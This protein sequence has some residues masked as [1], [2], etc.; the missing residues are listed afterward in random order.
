M[1]QTP[2]QLAPT[3]SVRP[4]ASFVSLSDLIHDTPRSTHAL[5]EK[6][7]AGHEPKQEANRE[8][9]ITTE[10]LSHK[11]PDGGGDSIDNDPHA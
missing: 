2:T 5:S 10:H 9:R 8:V 11:Q 6:E 7:V 4:Q 3:D 1:H